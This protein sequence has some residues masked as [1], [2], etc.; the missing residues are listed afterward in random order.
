[1]TDTTT[2]TTEATDEQDMLAAFESEIGDLHLGGED[3]W[4][5]FIERWEGRE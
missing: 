1:M 5:D 3:A 2:T 4:M